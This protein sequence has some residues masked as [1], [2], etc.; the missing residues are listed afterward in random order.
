MINNLK[1]LKNTNL[2]ELHISSNR[3]EFLEQNALNF[4]PRTI[5]KIL[6][7]GIYFTFGLCLLD[8]FYFH[9]LQW[10]NTTLQHISHDPKEILGSFIFCYNKK[11]T[12]FRRRFFIGTTNV[13][14]NKSL[15]NLSTFQMLRLINI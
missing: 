14:T 6:V 9:K 5:E 4:K 11:R 15:G 13:F 10:I 3:L 7:A 2:R 1:K 12:F 8:L